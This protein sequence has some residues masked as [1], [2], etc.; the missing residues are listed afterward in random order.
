VLDVQV[1]QDCLL[2]Y[3]QRRY[4]CF[5]GGLEETAQLFGSGEFSLGQEVELAEVGVVVVGEIDLLHFFESALP[6][7]PA[8][9]AEDVFHSTHHFENNGEGNP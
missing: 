6:A 8:E 9:D 4:G 5:G 1:Q 3:G 7:L 2:E